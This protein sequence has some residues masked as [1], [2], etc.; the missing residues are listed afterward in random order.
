M[1]DRS[2]FVL[3]DDARA[4]SRHLDTEHH[5]VD[6]SQADLL[7]SLPEAVARTEGLGINGQLPAK[8]LLA[9]AIAKAGF[10]VVLTPR[11]TRCASPAH[12][13]SGRSGRP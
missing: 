5:V 8:L 2:P 11:N 1:G 12:C 10:R 13:R 4:V 3:L 9:E 6:V 7:R